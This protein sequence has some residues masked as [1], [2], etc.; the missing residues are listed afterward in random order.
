MSTPSNFADE[1]S[2]RLTH[3]LTEKELTW[4]ARMIDQA[5]APVRECPEGLA[6]EGCY[7]ACWL[8]RGRDAGD[9]YY[10][11]VACLAAQRLMERLKQS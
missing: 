5:L 7:D 11:S 9:D 2:R 8:R 10:H 4:G 3:G 1:L 6:D